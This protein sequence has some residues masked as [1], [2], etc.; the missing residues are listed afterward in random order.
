M[1]LLFYLP[2]LVDGGAE[3]VMA[4]LAAS[5]HEDGHQLTFAVDFADGANGPVLPEGV[6][7]ALLGGGHAASVFG[8][9]RLIRRQQPQ[10]AVSAIASA[11]FKLT[12][13]MALCRAQSA[14]SFRR[15]R[16]KRGG[17]PKLV[18][19]Y[20]GFEEY[21]T[22]WM[23]WLG[24]ACLPLLSRYADRIVAV[25]D[26]L[27][28]DL[29]RR[30][31]ARAGTVIRIYNPV[32][33]PAATDA[34]PPQKTSPD[35]PK[36]ILSVGRLVADKRFDRLI[37]A[38]GELEDK[39]ARLIILGEGPERDSLQELAQ[40][41][42]LAARVDMP[43]YQADT[44]PWY[45]K[46]DCFALASKMES[47]GL[48][49]VEALAYGLPVIC[50]D[51]GGPREVLDNGRYGVLLTEAQQGDCAKALQHALD[52]PGDPAPRIQRAQSFSRQTGFWNYKTLF[53]EVLQSGEQGGG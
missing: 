29:V 45:A 32:G 52:H 41:L 10:L 46:A 43:G 7:A 18:L 13:A 25:S 17:A 50:N 19:C 15:K 27:A 4:E 40:R 36:I 2:G 47:F 26:A 48:V 12:A 22:G 42:G 44:G 53:A 3:R 5:F 37:R 49:L 21:K 28:N 35:A 24:Y 11:N 1:R 8:L 31:K 16:R 30:W 9:A 34:P 51:S 39:N 14:F 23:S 38:L 20:H 6:E 33:V